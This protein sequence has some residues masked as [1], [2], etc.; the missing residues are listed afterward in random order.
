MIK[1]PGTVIAVCI[2]ASFVVSTGMVAIT[3][4][5]IWASD[6]GE[7]AARNAADQQPGLPAEQDDIR[8]LVQRIESGHKAE[9]TLRRKLSSAA[10]EEAVADL[11]ALEEQRA[12][13]LA[14]YALSN[15]DY[16]IRLRAM[17]ML[18][19]RREFEIVRAVVVSLESTPEAIRGG[20]MAMAL[21]DLRKEQVRYV[22][23]L[24]GQ[25]AAASPPNVDDVRSAIEAGKRWL[26]SHLGS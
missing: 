5:C 20:E 10:W 19:E 26:L 21:E 14:M 6:T 1:P 25:S 8:K 12:P 4:P 3:T 9:E 23:R 2:A 16:E 18:A 22:G 11:R 24:T 17:R 7:I 15:P 13:G